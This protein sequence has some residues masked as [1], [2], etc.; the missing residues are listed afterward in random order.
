MSS[1][2]D[3]LCSV[4]AF[5][6]SIAKFVGLSS[7]SGEQASQQC[8]KL[9]YGLFAVVMLIIAAIMVALLAWSLKV[10]FFLLYG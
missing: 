10:N 2:V 3:S 1:I 7:T 5:G 4:G 8:H 9:I 6:A